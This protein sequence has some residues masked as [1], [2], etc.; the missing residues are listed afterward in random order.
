M[1]DP[2]VVSFEQA[3]KDSLSDALAIPHAPHWQWLVQV[4]D[5]GFAVARSRARRDLAS[6]DANGVWL[7]VRVVTTCPQWL[8][9][10]SEPDPFFDPILCPSLSTPL[11]QV[12][13]VSVLGLHKGKPDL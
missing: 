11:V 9:F 5:L 2:L 13:Q 1:S 7:A 3:A 8:R 6:I 10:V 4:M 12:I